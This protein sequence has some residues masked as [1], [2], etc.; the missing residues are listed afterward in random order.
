MQKND[1][2]IHMLGTLR[3]EWLVSQFGRIVYFQTEF[4]IKRQ[5]IAKKNVISSGST[6]TDENLEDGIKYIVPRTIQNSSMYWRELKNNGFLLSAKFS[7]TCFF[8][9]NPYNKTKIGMNLKILK[10]KI[11]FIMVLL[12]EVF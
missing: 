7:A 5:L 11:L 4:K 12:Y 8:F 10:N 6:F 9:F 3:E 1:S 2:W